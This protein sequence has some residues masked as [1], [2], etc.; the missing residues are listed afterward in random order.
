MQEQI[1]KD[2]L[3]GKSI[4]ELSRQYPM[5]YQAIQKLLIDN[6]IAIRGGRKKIQFSEDQLILLKQYFEE[7]GLSYKVIAKNFGV[8]QETIQR[9]VKEQGYQRTFNIRKKI[10]RFLKEDYFSTIDS[11]EKAYWLGFLFTD[12]SV[13]EYK[14]GRVRLQLQAAD[15]EILEKYKEDLNCGS[16]ISED[17]REN[18]TCLSVEFTSTKMFNDLAKYGIVPQKTYKTSHLPLNLIPKEYQT[19][20]LLG[21]FD[22]D[23]CIT[24]G[25]NF[26]E[27]TIGLTSYHQTIVE[28]FRDAIDA[29]INKE[30][31]NKAFF[32]SAW[33]VSWRGRQQVLK[34]MEILYNNC[35]RHLERKYQ[36]FLNVKES[37]S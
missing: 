17:K 36:K 32:S 11:A 26:S 30:N 2:Y 20:F 35:P 27:V 31:H 19:S 21:M 34:I 28:E 37:V 22:G 12:G 18:S 10:N 4:S 24:H 3:S 6:Q 13:D 9:I 5:S 25:E 8:S 14:G 33:H 1:I 15:K 23:G 7:D 16:K 29:L